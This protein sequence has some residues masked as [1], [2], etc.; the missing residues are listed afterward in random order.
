V[1]KETDFDLEASGLLDG[2]EGKART[3]RA[4]LIPANCMCTCPPSRS[5]IAGPVP[6]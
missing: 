1:P 5:V 6:L 2:L 3:E 4:E